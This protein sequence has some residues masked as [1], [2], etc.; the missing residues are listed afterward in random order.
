M[1]FIYSP[2]PQLRDIALLIDKC[3][4]KKNKGWKM[5]GSKFEDCKLSTYQIYLLQKPVHTPTHHFFPFFN[6]DCLKNISF[7]KNSVNKR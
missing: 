4:K 5:K 1:Y 3:W 2:P 7:V 6:R